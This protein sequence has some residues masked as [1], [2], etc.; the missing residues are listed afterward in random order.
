MNTIKQ[1]LRIAFTPLRKEP[2]QFGPSNVEIV[3]TRVMLLTVIAAWALFVMG[4]T[5]VLCK[6]FNN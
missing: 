4:E 2:D 1:I 6:A 3:F 5:T